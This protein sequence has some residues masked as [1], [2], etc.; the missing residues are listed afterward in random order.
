MILILLLTSYSIVSIIRSSTASLKLPK[1]SSHTDLKKHFTD[2]IILKNLNGLMMVTHKIFSQHNIRYW[3]I[4]GTLLGAMRHHDIIPWDDDLDIGVH[5]RDREKIF[6]LEKVFRENGYGITLCI[7]DII[8]IYPLEGEFYWGDLIHRMIHPMYP[9]AQ[10]PFLDIFLFDENKEN[11]NIIE[12]ASEITRWVFPNEHFFKHEISSLKL[13]PFNA[14]NIYIPQNPYQYLER[15][16]SKRW[17]IEGVIVS[18]HNTSLLS[19][20]F[21]EKVIIDLTQ[22]GSNLFLTEY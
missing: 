16:F 5:V 11:P 3:G 18:K 14:Y 7:G 6:S 21:P 12:Y 20:I 10:Y 19:F 13:T 22:Q 1:I 8:K 15:C 4:C 9:Y 17:N 2:P